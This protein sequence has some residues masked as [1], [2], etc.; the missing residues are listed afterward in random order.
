MR[1]QAATFTGKIFFISNLAQLVRS[2]YESGL[3]TAEKFVESKAEKKNCSGFFLRTITPGLVSFGVF[4]A[5]IFRVYSVAC[6]GLLRKIRHMEV[7]ENRLVAS[8]A[9]GQISSHNEACTC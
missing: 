4:G 6:T 5:A 3:F 1:N 8:I 7:D 9:S 2:L